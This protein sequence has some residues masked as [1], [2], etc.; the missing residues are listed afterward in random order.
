MNSCAIEYIRFSRPRVYECALFLYTRRPLAPFRDI[1]TLLWRYIYS[2]VCLIWVFI[3]VLILH[4]PGVSMGP[5]CS[6]VTR[7]YCRT[8]C[9]RRNSRQPPTSESG[10]RQ[11]N[12]P[13]NL[14]HADN[15]CILFLGAC[16]LFGCWSYD[17]HVRYVHSSVRS[18]G[19]G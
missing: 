11:R 18:C 13:S 7:G 4:G 19:I 3:V 17:G 2:S 5:I 1:R 16:P 15:R 14:F 8:L 6:L 10:H 9:F 12:H